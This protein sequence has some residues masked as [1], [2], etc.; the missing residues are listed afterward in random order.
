MNTD[1]ELRLAELRR[2]ISEMSDQE[3]ARLLD[4]TRNNRRPP[5]AKAKTLKVKKTITKTRKIKD[6][7]ATLI[8]QIGNLDEE[9]LQATLAKMKERAK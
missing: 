2:S 6:A 9:A 4:K 5:P 1:K 3:L 7:P 8:D